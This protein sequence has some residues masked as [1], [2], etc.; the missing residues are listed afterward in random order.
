MRTKLFPGELF[1]FCSNK[2]NKIKS[3]MLQTDVKIITL[4]ER[5]KFKS[6]NNT[7]FQALL[8]T[9]FSTGEYLSEQTNFAQYC[10]CSLHS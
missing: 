2:N 6:T 3:R 10:I 5:L 8:I 4:W 1:C 7:L 9:C